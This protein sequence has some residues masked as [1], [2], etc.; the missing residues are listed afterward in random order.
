MHI[1]EF[2]TWVIQNNQLLCTSLYLYVCHIKKT[3]YFA[4]HCICVSV[5]CIIISYFA[6][7]CI[8]YPC[9][10]LSLVILSSWKSRG[11]RLTELHTH[12][13][14]P[15]TMLVYSWPYVCDVGPTLNQH[16]FNGWCLLSVMPRFTWMRTRG[17]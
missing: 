16:C 4:H 7:H 11:Q 2:C 3:S 9:R 15:N 14:R 10:Y 17:T 5:R 6:H 1:T 8:L 12:I 13:H